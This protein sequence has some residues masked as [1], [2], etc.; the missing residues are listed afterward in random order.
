M[1]ESVQHEMKN[2]EHSTSGDIIGNKVICGYCDGRFGKKVWHSNDKYRKVVYR[3]NDK[4]TKN[5]KFNGKNKCESLTLTEDQIKN[6]F[7]ESLNEVITNKDEIIKNIE[8]TLKYLNTSKFETEYNTLETSL[9]TEID[10]IN[11]KVYEQAAGKDVEID[12]SK[13]EELKAKLD[14]VGEKI[15]EMNDKKNRLKEYVEEVRT[16][17]V[18][19]YR[20]EYKDEYL[21]QFLD[22]MVVYKDK[23]KIVFKDGREVVKGV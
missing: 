20:D 8:S 9:Q 22:K 10:K 2:R 1:F 23:V 3:C 4:F 11:N 14:K 19:K 12:H 21:G 18:S 13:Y 15:N 5:D 16:I 7:M 6:L 17:K